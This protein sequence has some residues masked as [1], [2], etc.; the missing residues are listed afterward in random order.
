MKLKSF[1]RWYK[2][3]DK[4][5]LNLKT[6]NKSTDKFEVL[7]KKYCEKE[8]EVQQLYDYFKPLF[9][10]IRDGEITKPKED[11]FLSNIHYQMNESPLISQ[12]DDLMNAYDEFDMD[13]CGD[14]ENP[15]Y[16]DDGPAAYLLM[17][18]DEEEGMRKTREK[19]R[20]DLAEADRKEREARK[21]KKENQSNS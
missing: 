19:I 5:K 3:Y 11:D 20:K 10:Q 13:L 1:I 15:L 21:Q 9:Q 8:K 7:L 17:D 4:K 18:E 2:L 6:L 14:R 12:Y 16:G